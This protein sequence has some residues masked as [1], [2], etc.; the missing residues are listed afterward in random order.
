MARLD[1]TPLDE[2]LPTQLVK[3][4]EWAEWVDE[5]EENI[6]LLDIGESFLQGEE[7]ERLPQPVMLKAPETILTNMFDYRIDLW[8]VGYLVG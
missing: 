8:R 4:V 7:P 6:R 1:G 2:S 5:D 3:A